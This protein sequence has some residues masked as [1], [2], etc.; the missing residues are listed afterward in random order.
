MPVDEA[1][2]SPSELIIER[3]AEKNRH[4]EVIVVEEST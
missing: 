3:D 1:A 2:V 4:A